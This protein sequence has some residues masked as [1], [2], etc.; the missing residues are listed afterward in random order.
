MQR[1]WISSLKGS[2]KENLLDLIGER[3][4]DKL[5]VQK[6]R[7]LPCQGKERSDLHSLSS[8][9][10]EVFLEDGSC[11]LVA[12][13]EAKLLSRFADKSLGVSKFL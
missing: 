12:K 11:E 8:V 6:F 5:V 13:G 4:S 2:D 7:F 10:E 9:L 3:L 1:V